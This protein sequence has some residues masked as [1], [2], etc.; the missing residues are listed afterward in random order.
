M[1]F[2]ELTAEKS[3]LATVGLQ[4]QLMRGSSWG[5]RGA[6][7]A[8]DKRGA[9]VHV[10]VHPVLGVS[11]GRFRR[12]AAHLSWNWR[13][14]SPYEPRGAGEGS[15]RGGSRSDKVRAKVREISCLVVG[16]EMEGCH[17]SP[18]P[19]ALQL[20]DRTHRVRGVPQLQN[21][22]PLKVDHILDCI[23]WNSN[24]RIP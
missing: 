13:S 17:S 23:T 10:P 3:L 9:G 20:S 19:D 8:G 7:Q 21:W 15:D 22:S 16:G 4:K 5:W 24:N 1:R 2:R 11:H 6:L 18:D 14:R 12:S